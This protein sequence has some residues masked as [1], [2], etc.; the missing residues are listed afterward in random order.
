MNSAEISIVLKDNTGHL[1]QNYT[2]HHLR[3]GKKLVNMLLH[4]ITRA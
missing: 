3:N 1:Q 4:E 2:K